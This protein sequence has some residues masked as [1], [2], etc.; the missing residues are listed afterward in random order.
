VE[1]CRKH[2]FCIQFTIS[3]PLSDHPK[4]DIFVVNW[5]GGVGWE[6]EGGHDGP[7][8]D[9]PNFGWRCQRAEF[10]DANAQR[11]CAGGGGG[12]TCSDDDERFIYNFHEE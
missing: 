7:M 1:L 3:I 4:A 2:H 11:L 10:R 8:M 12:F 9:G 5:N 6:G